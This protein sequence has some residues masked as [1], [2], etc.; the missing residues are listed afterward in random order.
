MAILRGELPS[1]CITSIG[2]TLRDR[3]EIA[4][5][6]FKGCVSKPGRWPVEIGRDE[7]GPG[8]RRGARVTLLSTI[9]LRAMIG[10]IST[11]SA[12]S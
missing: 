7:I 1:L 5:S 3:F 6:G 10:L 4:T 9:S 2:G 8:A 12:Q 11:A